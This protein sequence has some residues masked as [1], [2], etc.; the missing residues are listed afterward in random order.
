VPVL[1]SGH[2]DLTGL[3]G[4][5]G[6]DFSYRS[7]VSLYGR[8]LEWS[9]P[10]VVLQGYV[11]N[12]DG[13]TK[14]RISRMEQGEEHEP[15]A[16]EVVAG[17]QLCITATYFLEGLTSSTLGFTG[18]A[19]GVAH[20][21]LSAIHGDT[22]PASVVKGGMV[23]GD[24]TPKWGLFGPNTTATKKYLSMVSSVPSWGVIEAG[25]VPAHQLDGS[26]HTVSGLTP[27]HFLK[28]LTANTF[29]FAAHGLTYSDVGAAASGHN[30]SGVY[31]PVIS[32]G[33]TAQ[34]WRG[35]KSWQTLNQA[36]IPELTDTSGPTFAHLHL[37]NT[38]MCGDLTDG[39]MPY[40]V[41]DAAGLANS[42][43]KVLGG[44][45]SIGGTPTA[46]VIFKI[47]GDSTTGIYQYGNFT[48]CTLSGTSQSNMFYVGGTIKAATAITDWAQFRIG[49]PDLGAGASVVNQYGLIIGAPTY[50]SV[51]NY[52]IYAYG[53]SYFVGDVNC[54]SLTDHT[55]YPKTKL[56]AYAA[57]LS[58][59][60]D[61]KGNLI[62]DR[63]HESIRRIYR[64]KVS[65]D[66]EDTR[67]IEL[68]GR[69]LSASVSAINEVTKDLVSR[70]RKLEMSN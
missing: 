69:N 49:N 2:L 22:V 65:E 46:T 44:N 9:G 14:I 48:D 52:A 70:V 13:Q 62:H 29:S 35:D 4:P 18:T 3:P 12:A 1:P 54:G 17:S 53:N 26:I 6:A 10:V 60:G 36:A 58:M 25:D 39:Y 16:H 55:V 43:I 11:Y 61:D 59:I 7:A 68:Q 8:N 47:L 15:F 50:G 64:A 31:E 27:G 42:P 32:A 38:I 33:S 19:S 23:Y 41:S 28:A 21:L 24:A 5:V 40:H 57:V 20:N 51:I 30:H 67:T 45:V 34:Y 56:E 66:R 63:L 37:T